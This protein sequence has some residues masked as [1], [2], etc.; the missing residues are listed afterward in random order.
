M[1]RV[2]VTGAGGV[3]GTALVAHLETL[4]QTV[5]ALR[6][7]KD[8]DLESFADARAVIRFVN[9]THVY[10]LAGAV[11]G[12]GG[13]LS[14]PGDAFRR[15]ILI[16]THV[17]QACHDVGVEKI[18][19]MG[20]AAMY[21]DGL[22]QPFRED[23]VLLGRPH[24]SEEAYGFAKRALLIQLESYHAQFG[25]NWAFAV[26]TNMYGPNDRFDVQNGHVIP[27]LVSK[28]VRA[29]ETGEPVEV[30]GDGSPSR[31]F[32]YAE[33][34]A[35][36]LALMMKIGQGPFNLATGTSRRIADVVGALSNIFPQVQ[37]T[38]DSSKPLGQLQRSYEV[39][40]LGALGFRAEWSLE[41]G[42]HQ[43]VAWFKA[44]RTLAR[45]AI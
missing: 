35:R 5:V 19:A 13:N 41:R 16:N 40:R 9:P 29:S 39:S 3:V 14:F 31:D 34:A 28:F 18:V 32:L 26:A 22:A 12:L 7:R 1:Q 33:D 24:G 8:C 38:W 42:I 20:S 45:T 44:N 30:W 11:F 6:S 17:V 4:G 27:S 15:N 25:L 10:H 37:V 2:L 21:T 36:G 43:T 23:D